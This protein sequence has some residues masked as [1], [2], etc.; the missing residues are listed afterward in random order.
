MSK[1][2]SLK[3][4]KFKE[5]RSV[6]TRRERLLKLQRNLKWLEKN[7]SAYGL[8]K[9]KIIRLKLKIAKEEKKK[10]IVPLYSAPVEETRKKKTSRDDTETRK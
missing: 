6:R 1:H 9:E 7:R 10:E 5:V 2:P 4:N 3:R 8:P